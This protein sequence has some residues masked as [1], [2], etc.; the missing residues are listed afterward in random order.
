MGTVQNHNLELACKNALTSKLFKS[1]DEMLLRLFYLY[2]RS[3]KK[4][5][6]LEE[7]MKELQVVFEFPKSG[8]KPVQSQG[9]R[10]INHKRFQR[11]VDRYGAYVMYLLRTVL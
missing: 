1:I 6:E 8:N 7:V 4:P 10:W 11:V 9:S 5:R 2:E 3:L